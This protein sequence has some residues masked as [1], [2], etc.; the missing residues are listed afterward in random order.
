MKSATEFERAATDDEPMHLASNNALQVH[1][2]VLPTAFR[3]AFRTAFIT[4][5]I[6]RQTTHARF[7]IALPHVDR[8][9][10]VIHMFPTWTLLQII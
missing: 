1:L 8:V 6:T 4:I 7:S 5:N 2:L 9:V 3:T 10:D